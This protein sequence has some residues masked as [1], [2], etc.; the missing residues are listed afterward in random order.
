MTIKSDLG[1]EAGNLVRMTMNQR[2]E[3]V[4]RAL[5]VAH[6]LQDAVKDKER[7]PQC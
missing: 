3:Y 2:D 4:G 7:H 6:R 5:N 1:A